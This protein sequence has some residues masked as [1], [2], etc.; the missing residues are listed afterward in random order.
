MN[1]L[2]RSL[3]ALL[4]AFTGTLPQAWAASGYDLTDMWWNPQESGWGIQ[5]VQQRD[6]IVADLYVYGADGRPAW[7]TAALDFQGLAA[8]THEMSYAGDLYAT[9]G[10]WF[11]ASPFSLTAVRKVGTMTVVAPTMST[12]TLTYSVDGVTMT[13]SIRRYTFRW[14]DYDGTYSGV[15][16]VTYTKCNNPADEGTRTLPTSY[17]IARSGAQMTVSATD[18]AKSCT[19]SG[20]Y[21]QD[22]RLGRLDATYTCSNG[23]VGA[24]ALEEMDIQ[25]FGLMGRLFGANNRSCKIEGRFA[26][27]LQ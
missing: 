19:Y 21:S 24:M 11:G 17:T 16:S 26:A 13:K 2:F 4:L 15:H 27:V 20:T 3:G 22:G 9:N 25:R 8:Q 1:S 18:G 7:Y 5:F 12:A 10:S 14:D 6:V 23:E